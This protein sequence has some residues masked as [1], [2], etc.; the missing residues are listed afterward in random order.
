MY[1][2]AVAFSCNKSKNY[3]I[4]VPVN[5]SVLSSA[6][7]PYTSIFHTFMGVIIGYVYYIPLSRF[8]VEFAEYTFTIT[9]SDG[10]DSASTVLRWTS[11]GTPTTTTTTTTTDSPLDVVIE[12]NDP[13][14][15]PCGEINSKGYIIILE[16]K[17][18]PTLQLTL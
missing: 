8:A 6:D 7:G 3:H 13:I 10:T 2:P 4:L 15:C 9:S 12:T 17:I 1:N 16:I 5:G 18:C 14:E 11:P